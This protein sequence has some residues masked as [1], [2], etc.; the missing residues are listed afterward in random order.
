MKKF[1]CG[2]LLFF[3]STTLFG[4]SLRLKEKKNKWGYINNQKAWVIKP[5]FDE[6]EGFNASSA[7]VK[8]DGKYQ[9]INEKGDFLIKSEY[10]TLYRSGSY[11]IY[12]LSS[13]YG[14][15]DSL[16]IQLSEPIFDKV[17][18]F[19]KGNFTVKKDGK[20]V[21][22]SLDG[23]FKEIEDLVFVNPDEFPVF[24][25]NCLE[26]KDL[27]EKKECS[28]KSLLM[29][30]YKNI[31]YPAFARKNEIQGT[32]VIGFLVKSDG[33]LTDFELLKDVGGGCGEEALRVVKLL[34]VYHPPM[35]EGSPVTMKFVLPVKYRLE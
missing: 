33:S 30:I 27:E 9:L 16:G 5:V 29:S 1:G 28:T 19:Y 24:G 7:L 32:V 6:A 23:S 3:V 26:M 20:W 21:A 4:Q 10:D 34:K 11:V 14:I 31:Q 12:H 13:N 2:I 35:M 8:L 25:S 18:G 15:L 17:D 22:W